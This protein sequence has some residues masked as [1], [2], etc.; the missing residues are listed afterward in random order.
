M[1]VFDAFNPLEFYA[2]EV[3][4]EVFSLRFLLA[5]AVLLAA[6]LPV[7]A[8]LSGFTFRTVH[9]LIIQRLIIG[10]SEYGVLKPTHLMFF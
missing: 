9:L 4:S 2:F 8:D 7:F 6:I 1:H 10:N 3:Y 5:N